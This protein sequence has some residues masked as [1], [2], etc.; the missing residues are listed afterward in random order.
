VISFS[1]FIII[2]IKIFNVNLE[3]MAKTIDHRERYENEI[4]A[5]SEEILRYLRDNK[6]E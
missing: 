1:K 4:L 3:K 6:K 5:C 2:L